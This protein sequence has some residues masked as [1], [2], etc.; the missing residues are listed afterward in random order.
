MGGGD[1]G[2][3]GGLAA[4]LDASAQPIRVP[5]D[6]QHKQRITGLTAQ[7]PGEVTGEVTG[8]LGR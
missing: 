1:W 8:E 4:T 6:E 5:D 7:M 3:S 2:R